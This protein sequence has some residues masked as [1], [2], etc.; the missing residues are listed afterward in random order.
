MTAD[1][2]KKILPPQ[3]VTLKFAPRLHC[4]LPIPFVVTLLGSAENKQLQYIH[5]R[6]NKILIII[7][8]NNVL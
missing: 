7:L 4:F 6:L 1:D 3:N 5:V 8:S 2:L